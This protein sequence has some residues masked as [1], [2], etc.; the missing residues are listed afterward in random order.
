MD[1]E[2]E[3]H[4]VS[5]LRSQDNCPSASSIRHKFA[6]PRMMHRFLLP[7]AYFARKSKAM[8]WNG[9]RL[10]FTLLVAVLAA[11]PRRHIAVAVERA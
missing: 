6:I 4:R 9:S 11:R 3:T 7:S 2:F 5:L 1:P 10:E 8:C